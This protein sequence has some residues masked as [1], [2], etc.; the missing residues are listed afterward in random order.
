[1][2]RQE[3]EIIGRKPN[4]IMMTCILKNKLQKF[5]YLHGQRLL[6]L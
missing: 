5:L 3:I 4:L 2:N 1:M 6:P